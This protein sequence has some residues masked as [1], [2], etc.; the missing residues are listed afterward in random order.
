MSLSNGR[1]S[2]GAL[3][4]RFLRGL[5]D[6]GDRRMWGALGLMI[7]LGLVEGSGLLLLA[8]MLKVVGI[9]PGGR[10]GDLSRD[11]ADWLKD[12]NLALTLPVLLGA[13]LVLALFKALVNSYLSVLSAR[14]EADYTSHLR[15][16]F[17]EAMMRAEWLFF[18]RQR[19]SDVVHVMTTD[20]LMVALG[21]G[22]L[23]TV[24]TAAS[25]VLIDLA[26]AFSVSVPMTTFSLAVGAVIAFVVRP[27]AERLHD[28]GRVK[29]GH[30]AEFASIVTEH[31]GGMKVAKSHAREASHLETFE[32]VQKQIAISSVLFARSAARRTIWYQLGSAVGLCGFSLAAV[33]LLKLGLG[34]MMLLAFVFM[35]LTSRL[36]G[37]QTAW[38]RIMQIMPQFEAAED[39]RNQF[40]AAAE[41]SGPS[42][43]E[44]LQ[45]EREI[46]LEDVSFSYQ[47]GQS[48]PAVSHVNLVIRARAA[49]AICGPSGAG[50]STMA[51]LVLGLIRPQSGRILIDGV[52]LQGEMY[53]RWRQSMG[54]VPQETFLF[55]SSIRSNL[56]WARAEATEDELWDALKTA[57]AEEFVRRLP[58]GLDTVIGD[59]G[60][61]LS[62]GERQRLA[63][64][65][66]LLRKPA[67][68]VL[69]EATSALDTLNER[70][71]QE[72]IEKLHGKLTIV[73]IAHRLSTVRAAEQIIV[74]DKGV[75]VETGSWDELMSKKDGAFRKLASS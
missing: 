17:Y 49:T 26:F 68:L 41:P 16:R 64:A 37:I 8:P 59:R 65:R 5:L 36:N 40:L 45:P 28:Q 47:T 63:L 69:D 53:Q 23:L 67:V 51:D 11:I 72:A 14:I 4:R 15:R 44:G 21:A 3:F 66:A 20:L 74:L 12:W 22:Q 57:A 55:H 24:L 56:L 42:R 39:L 71:I 70:F 29:R 30:R 27:L 75:V 25:G 9:T 35:R 6:Y 62:G 31:L 54:Y 2:Q 50:K 34:E 38:Q 43:P 61:K 33:G 48:S 32:Q 18:T 13:F 10:Q 73:L 60:V 7:A 46:R 19:S 1:R 58:D 52:P